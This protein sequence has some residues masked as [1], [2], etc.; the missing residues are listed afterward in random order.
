MRK[1]QGTDFEDDEDEAHLYLQFFLTHFVQYDKKRM[2]PNT[3]TH[4][5]SFP[6]SGSF[7]N[8]PFR[9]IIKNSSGGTGLGMSCRAGCPL[10][11]DPIPS[12]S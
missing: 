7:F 9:S 5:F 4:T 12:F 1:R 6:L 10:I 3:H 2:P 11:T 8:M